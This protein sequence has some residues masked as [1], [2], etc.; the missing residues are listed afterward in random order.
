MARFP[1]RWRRL[2]RTAWSRPQN[3]PSRDGA[4]LWRPFLSSG[5]AHPPPGPALGSDQ[6]EIRAA[7]RTRSESACFPKDSLEQACTSRSSTTGGSTAPR[8][9]ATAPS[10]R[11]AAPVP[12]RRK[13]ARSHEKH[14]KAP[15]RDDRV[16]GS[17][18]LESEL[19]AQILKQCGTPVWC[20]QNQHRHANVKHGQHDGSRW[21][22]PA[23]CCHTCQRC[24]HVTPPCT[25][26]QSSGVKRK[27]G[28]DVNRTIAETQ[29]RIRRTQAGVVDI[30]LLPQR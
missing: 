15:C 23:P 21:K 13:P 8:V 25:S 16:P 22:D 29:R 17:C 9:A 18:E 20:R 12:K 2:E 26:N 1:L 27:A 6:R 7:N 28:P 19:P 24:L 30:P 10:A 4:G 14:K 11:S 5:H 3:R